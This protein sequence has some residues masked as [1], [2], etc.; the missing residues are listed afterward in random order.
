MILT[1]LPRLR[2]QRHRYFTHLI[3][4][5]ISG[6]ALLPSC[7]TFQQYKYPIAINHSHMTC[8][9]LGEVTEW[10]PNFNTLPL[11]GV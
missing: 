4:F 9:A 8:H 3:G 6:S 1:F 2:S 10:N 5:I 7:S 11:E